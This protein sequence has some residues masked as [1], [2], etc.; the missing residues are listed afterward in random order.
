MATTTKAPAAEETEAA[1]AKSKK[2]L[3]IV[4]VAVL[5]AAAAAYFLLLKGGG[6]AEVKEPVPG[7]VLVNDPITLNL[8]GG[9][10]LKVGLAL[11][12]TEEAG[13]GGHGAAPD[14]SHA[15]DYMIE[16]FTGRTVA[17]LSNPESRHKL[18]EHLLE[19]VKHAY[20]DGVMDIYFTEFVIQ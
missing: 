15:L 6:E 12:F 19:E 3:I 16:Q 5:V 8:Q 17:E 13:G 20:H 10:Y 1:P 4:A 18:K 2:K 9:H 11:Q 14:G 7:A